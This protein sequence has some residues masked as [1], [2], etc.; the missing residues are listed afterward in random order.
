M[1]A[2]LFEGGFEF[3]MNA[4]EMMIDKMNVIRIW[5]PLLNS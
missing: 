5:T 2:F 4:N 3:M 1:N